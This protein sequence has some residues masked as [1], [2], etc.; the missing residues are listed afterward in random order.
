MSDEIIGAYEDGT[1]GHQGDASEDRAATERDTG[2]TLVRQKQAINCLHDARFQGLTAREIGA[3]LGWEHQIY[4]SILSTLHRGG[5]VAKLKQRRDRAGI[6]VLPEWVADRETVAHRSNGRQPMALE[7]VGNTEALYALLRRWEAAAA[8]L[9]QERSPHP[10]GRQRGIMET[11]AG[12]LREA[13]GGTVPDGVGNRAVY[14]ALSGVILPVDEV[15]LTQSVR[16]EKMREVA[17]SHIDSGR[18]DLGSLASNRA[19]LIDEVI[20]SLNSAI[21]P[22]RKAWREAWREASL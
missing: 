18:P 17:K 6:Y 10:A 11:M 12:E 3:A 2:K 21:L 16:A 14:E 4:S 19:R 22:G 7:P 1:T 9:P 13:L 5:A 20:E 15:I 8:E